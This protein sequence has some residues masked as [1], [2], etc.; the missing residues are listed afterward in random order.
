M[1]TIGF[2]SPDI[3]HASSEGAAE[4]TGS[5]AETSVLF[6]FDDNTRIHRDEAVRSTL[7]LGSTGSGKTHSI[8]LPMLDKLIGAEYGG[9][10]IDVKGNL[11][12]HVHSLAA[13]HGRGADVLEIGSGPAAV[14]LNLL[15]GMSAGERRDF[16]HELS[17]I[18]VT[19]DYNAGWYAKGGVLA[20]DVADVLDVL[21]HCSALGDAADLFRPTLERV[22][23]VLTDW[24]FAAAI[25][26][27]GQ[28]L[29]RSG[30]IP[31]GS[32]EAM[33]CDDIRNQHFHVFSCGGN[34][35]TD[36]EFPKQLTWM[37][38]GVTKTFAQ[39]K[40]TENLLSRFSSTAPDAPTLDFERE[41]YQ[42]NHIVLVHFSPACGGAGEILSRLCKGRSYAAMYARGLQLP[43]DR[44]TFF[45]G[46][47]FQA[48]INVDDPF[49]NDFDFFP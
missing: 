23:L 31:E 5:S 27:L 1:T 16:F 11:G 35:T 14:S 38:Q 21:S 22:Y 26:E 33:A 19:Q 6:A 30:D 24:N 17:M 13:L 8:I 15:E 2:L 42:N 3:V 10:V 43:A 46:D 49:G 28:E 45:V 29:L 39:L 40:N 7:I 25:W 37:L 4:R 12:E 44:Y 34:D 47:V 48:I 9:V 20:S 36:M 18:G 32:E 41:V